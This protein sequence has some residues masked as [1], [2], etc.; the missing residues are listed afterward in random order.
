[1]VVGGGGEGCIGLIGFRVYTGLQTVDAVVSGS[2]ASNQKRAGASD[3][4]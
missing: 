3:F 4:G 2:R 1:M